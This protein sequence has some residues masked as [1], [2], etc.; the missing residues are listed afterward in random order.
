MPNLIGVYDSAMFEIDTAKIP[1]CQINTM[2]D[3]LLKDMREFFSQPGVNEEYRA[4]KKEQE[5]KGR[6]L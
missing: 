1:Q 5:Q 3:A 6:R 4:W 2:L